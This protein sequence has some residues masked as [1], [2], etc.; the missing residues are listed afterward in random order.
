MKEMLQHLKSF[1]FILHPSAF[2]LA[3]SSLLFHLRFSLEETDEVARVV[4]D[5]ERA[6]AVLLHNLVGAGH[7]H[8]RLDEKLWAHGAHHVACARLAPTLAR[9]SLE[10]FAQRRLRR[11]RSVHI[12]ASPRQGISQV[13]QMS[14]AAPESTRRA[15]M[16][17]SHNKGK[18]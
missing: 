12:M 3:F 10:F 15:D 17:N 6:R 13:G 7:A 8:R 1:Y 16:Q 11:E 18:G 5:G 2:I 4:N 9:Q 14:F